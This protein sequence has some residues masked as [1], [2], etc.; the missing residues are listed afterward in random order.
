MGSMHRAQIPA[1][2]RTVPRV[3]T[4][5]INMLRVRSSRRGTPELRS[6]SVLLASFVLASAS[7]AQGPGSGGLQD[8]T[9]PLRRF[10][11]SI[12]V[13]RPGVADRV[14]L[15]RLD[16]LR[17]KDDL[18]LRVD[19]KL[20][21]Q[22]TFVAA[23]LSAGQ[24]IKLRSW[25]LWE[26]RWQRE[27]VPVGAVPEGDVVPLYFLVLNRRSEKR[28]PNAI[29]AAL[30]AAS[31]Q[32]VSQ[33]ATFQTIYQ[34]QNRLLNFMS[35]YAALGPKLTDD[36]VQL[37]CRIA[38]INSDL[39]VNYDV[40]SLQTQPAELQRGLQAGVGVLNVL[41][42]T[43]DNPTATA[44]VVQSQLPSVVSDWVGLVGSLMRI[45]VRPPRQVKISFVPASAT[46]VDPLYAPAQGPRGDWMQFVTERVLESSNDALPALVFRPTFSPN[47]ASK[48]PPLSF[49]RADAIAGPTE[50]AVPVASSANELFLHPWVSDWE[51]SDDGQTFTPLDSARLVAGR[52]VVFPIDEG[53]WR[54]QYQRRIFLRAKIGFQPSSPQAVTVYRGVP[55][56]WAA[57]SRSVSDLASGDGSV[58]IRLNRSGPEQG[59]YRYDA[60]SLVDSSGRS[61]GAD[62]VVY[63]N[64]L[65]LR[66]DLRNVAPGTATIRIRGEGAVADD[67]AQV[68]VAPRRPAIGLYY[69]KG[70][71]ILRVAGPDAG[72]V[73][74]VQLPNVYVKEAD[75]SN[76]NNRQLTLSGPLAEGAKTVD[77][78]FRDPDRGLEWTRTLPISVGLPRPKIVATL[79]DSITNTMAIGGGADPNWAIATLPAGWFSTRTPIRLQLTAQNP[80]EWTHDVILDL[81]LGSAGDVQ[82]VA[83][84]PEGTAFVLDRMRP[85]AFVTLNLDTGLPQNPKRNSGLLWI[86]LTRSDLASPWTLGTLKSDNGSTPL[87]GVRLPTVVSVEAT[88]SGGTKI[89]LA[90]AEEVFGIRFAGQQNFV[91][92]TLV[93]SSGGLTAVFEGPANV[94]DFDLQF[95][96]AADGVV[97][98]K[99]APK[100]G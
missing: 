75:N 78:T 96:D 63:D 38:A 80:F 90:G 31:E 27:P 16:A 68:F 89:T 14:S 95:R 37:K 44:S 71:Q 18:E 77:V 69:G 11:I 65:L 57:E 52:G 76:P 7:W 64:G 88:P 30:E 34:Q 41:R 97:S 5:N 50:V 17:P 54:G 33:T 42:Q 13:R 86:R 66:F 12:L 9:A 56:Q 92:P 82:P 36:P 73:K 59:L 49:A 21:R 85:D 45:F 100:Q 67:T 72:W 74:S 23:T 94:T 93:P 46:E 40:N 3:R 48:V 70:D 20:A 58:T 91:P 2:P 61:T 55:Q 8:P 39:G 28:V 84:I 99:L 51:I 47:G 10:P 1:I 24:R 32:I 25:N 43:P 26:K 22:W 4:L 98:V 60:V 83:T 29:Q 15:L 53:W 62:T 19:P 81:G 87:R 79:A 6:V 35:A